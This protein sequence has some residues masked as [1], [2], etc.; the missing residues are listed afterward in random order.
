MPI[1]YGKLI[2]NRGIVMSA[3]IREYNPFGERLHILGIVP[4]QLKSSAYFLNNVKVS[5]FMSTTKIMHF[6]D[7][8]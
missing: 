1:K 7:L 2:D 8:K 5:I 4:S 6:R 3:C